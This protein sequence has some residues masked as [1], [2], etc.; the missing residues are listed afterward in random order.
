MMTARHVVPQQRR[1]LVHV[2]DHYVNITIIIEVAE[3]ATAARMRNFQIWSC[4][5][6]QL[7]EP[8][9]SQIPKEHFGSLVGRTPA[10]IFSASG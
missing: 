7:L 9:V 5:S 4:Y 8:A 6:D 2:H 1:R 3:R 10:A